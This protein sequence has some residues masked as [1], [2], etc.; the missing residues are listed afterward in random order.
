[1]FEPGGMSDYKDEDG[2]P[3][4]RRFAAVGGGLL[5]VGAVLPW[6]AYD[7]SFGETLEGTTAGIVG[8]QGIVV[9]LAGLSIVAVALFADR[10][11]FAAA[12]VGV[13]AGLALATAFPVWGEPTS[14]TPGV[15]WV[16]TGGRSSYG[17]SYGLWITILGG[18]LACYE[19]LGIGWDAAGDERT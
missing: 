10:D 4:R 1:M 9:L 6:T 13:A 3:W 14:F 8:W 16:S 5:A 17:S 7:M 11:G 18:L 19:A 12:V 2:A 15:D